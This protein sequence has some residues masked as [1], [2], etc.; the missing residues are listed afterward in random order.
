MWAFALRQCPIPLVD[1]KDIDDIIFDKG[2]SPDSSFSHPLD[3]AMHLDTLCRWIDS[4][5]E[6]EAGGDPRKIIDIANPARLAESE[7]KAILHRCERFNLALY[8]FA[9]PHA[10]DRKALDRFADA[11]G[12]VRRDFSLDADARGIVSVRNTPDQGTAGEMIPFTDR[13]LNWHSD[14]YYHRLDRPI[15]SI[16]MHC[17][18][19][20][21]AGGENGFIDP[22]RLFIALHDRD[23]T[24]VEA[25]A[26]PQAMT[27]PGVFDEKGRCLRPPRSGPVFS[28]SK[29]FGSDSR[30]RLSM[31]YTSRTRSI[32]W[33]EEPSVTEARIA[34]RKTIETL[35]LDA[36]KIRFEAG[37]GIICNNVLHCRSA[38]IDKADSPRTLLRIRGFDPVGCT[39]DC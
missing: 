4:R 10:A 12:L 2:S 1:R 8:R 15:R 6:S 33:R 23:P 38:F 39:K 18:Q 5:R 32:R 21:A 29:R 19:P 28:F 36:L 9:R 7:R 20:A 22:D 11:L 16:V 31:R 30:L 26:H 35:S 34:L 3:E 37:E 17:A 25:L 27:V 14:G 13:A 24:L